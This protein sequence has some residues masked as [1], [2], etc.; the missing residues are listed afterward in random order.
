MDSLIL[1]HGALGSAAQMAP[2]ARELES[3]FNVLV[4]ELPG[5]GKTSSVA[6]FS[7]PAFAEHV[8]RFIDGRGVQRAHFFGYSMG[9]YV[10]LFIAANTPERVISVTTL[11]TKFCWTPEVAAKE[12]KRLD[13]GVIRGKVPAF[14]ASLEKRHREAGG[15][16]RMIGRTA[17]LVRGL[18][19]QPVLNDATLRRISVPVLVMVGDGDTTVSADETELASSQ[20]ADAGFRLLPGT[21]H[22]IEQVSFHALASEVR[23]FVAG[24]HSS[25]E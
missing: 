10:A 14:A 4:V 15:W 21:P 9:G 5:H 12:C 6:P 7:I 3:E 25:D 22:P 17:D 16:E 23:S 8:L 24:Q 20:I 1:L 11:G 13:A 2:L 18:G 19:D